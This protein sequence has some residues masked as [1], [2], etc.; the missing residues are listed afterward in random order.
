MTLADGTHV[1]LDA[2]VALNERRGYDVANPPDGMPIGE[3]MRERMEE[4]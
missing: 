2:L 1:V 3:V 4:E